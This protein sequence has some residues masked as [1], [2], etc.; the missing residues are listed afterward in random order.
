MVVFR[1]F[2]PTQ[3]KVIATNYTVSKTALVR[4]TNYISSSCEFPTVY[5]CQKNRKLVD[6]VYTVMAIIKW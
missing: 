1:N 6:S 3:Q 2:Y 5:V 4:L